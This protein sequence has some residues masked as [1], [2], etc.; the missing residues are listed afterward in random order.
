VAQ[1]SLAV[2]RVRVRGHHIRVHLAASRGLRITC[3]LRHWTGRRWRTARTKSCAA[4]AVFRHVPA[5]RYRLR[6]SSAAGTVSRRLV[7]R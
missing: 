6:V 4:R 7:V 3:S 2:A 1:V 5:G